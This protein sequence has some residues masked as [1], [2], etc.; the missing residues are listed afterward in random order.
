VVDV[1]ARARRGVAH[2]HPAERRRATEKALEDESGGTEETQQAI[3]DVQG[4][5][6]QLSDSVQQLDERVQA[7]EEQQAA[8]Q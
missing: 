4:D 6:Q 1:S 5:V 2:P 8:S 7:V 3:E